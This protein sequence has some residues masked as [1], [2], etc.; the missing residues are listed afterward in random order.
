[1]TTTLRPTGPIQRQS[2]GGRS[3]L[4]EV[5]DNGR[6]VGRVTVAAVP[7]DGARVGTVR[8]LWIDEPSRRRG[9][10]TIAALAAEEVLRGWDCDTVQVSVPSG[11]DA[12]ARL[13]AALGYTGTGRA[14]AKALD[15]PP[16]ALPPGTTHRPISRGEYTAWAQ[17]ATE[18]YARALAAHGLPLERARAKAA[19]DR[20]GVLPQG[21]DTPGVRLETL[22]HDGVPAGFLWLAPR[23]VR[24]GERGMWVYDVMVAEEYRGRG[25]G[26]ALMLVAE[27]CALAAGLRLLGLHVFAD[28]APALRLYTSLGYRTV[29]VHHAKPLL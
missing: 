10:G 9:R 14:M 2:D 6:P 24:P 16:P 25:H 4:Y 5:C 7:S 12:A 28:N 15:G 13:A 1:M 3:R 11:A 18:G 26:R 22:V 17:S 27:R 23:E 21:P 8:D 20:A 19:A 29:E